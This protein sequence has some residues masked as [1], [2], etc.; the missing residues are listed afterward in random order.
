MNSDHFLSR[1][2]KSGGFTDTRAA[3]GVVAAVLTVL[4]ARL[5]PGTA[6]ALADRMPAFLSEALEERPTGAAERY[7]VEE[8][9]RRVGNL[10]GSGAREARR[11]VEVVLTAL[12]D[13]VSPGQLTLILADLPRGYAALFGTAEPHWPTP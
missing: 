10:T 12:V 11:D 6:G 9:C 5:G 2:Q 3:E 4:A 13:A 1:V 8:F 7:G